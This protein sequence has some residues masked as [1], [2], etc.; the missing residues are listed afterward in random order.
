MANE[1]E[2]LEEIRNLLR[3]N[4]RSNSITPASTSSGSSGGDALNISGKLTGITTDVATALTRVWQGSTTA[5]DGLNLF[6]TSLSKNGGPIG[7]IL[8]DLGSTAIT[9]IND[10]NKA[11]VKAA[12]Y[13]AAQGNNLGEFDKAVKGA[14]MTHE[15]Y[16]DMLRDATREMEG[17]GSTAGRSQQNMLEIM[18]SVQESK[19]ANNLK[20]L[21]VSTEEINRIT[22]TSLAFRQGEDLHDKKAR[23]E[24]VESAIAMARAMDENTRISGLSRKAQE[25]DLKK[26]SEDAALQMSLAKLGPEARKQYEEA[27]TQ[28][29][30]MPKAVKDAFTEEFTGG[31]RTEG[32]AATIAALGDAGPELLKSAEAIRDANNPEAREQ[33]NDKLVGAITGVSKVQRTGSYLDLGIVGTGAAAD[34][35]REM[36]TEN[37]ELQKINA[38]IAEEKSK[39]STIDEATARKMIV[40]EVTNE[41]KKLDEKGEPLKGGELGQT[42]NKADSALKDMAA[43]ASVAFDKLV[44]S[45]NGV[46]SANQNYVDKVLKPR[47]QEEA[48]PAAIGKEIGD[49]IVKA[50]P[51]DAGKL[52]DAYSKRHQEYQDANKN[53]EEL[54]S[55]APKRSTGSPPFENFLSG[56]G[57]IKDMFESFDP[58]GELVELHG[59]ELVA[60]ESQMNRL[61]GQIS[62]EMQPTAISTASASDSAALNFEDVK[63]TVANQTNSANPQM[64]D[65]NKTFTAVNAEMKNVTTQLSTVADKLK[66]INFEPALKNLS[67]HT[68]KIMEA[69]AKPVVAPPVVTPPVVAKSAEPKKE[70]PKKEEVKKEEVKKEEVKPAETKPVEDKFAALSKT[71]ESVTTEIQSGGI[72][73]KEGAEKMASLGPAGADLEKAIKA[74]KDATTD[75]QKA[76]AINAENAAVAKIKDYQQSK[77]I[78]EQQQQQAIMSA[79]ASFKEID[80][81][82]STEELNKKLFGALKVDGIEKKEPPKDEKPK[83]PEKV[84]EKKEEKG[85]FDNVSDAFTKVGSSITD[86]FKDE[87][88]AF[89]KGNVK[90]E[91]IP[92]EEQDAAT[93]RAQEGIGK[94]DNSPEAM[95]AQKAELD[96]QKNSG[97]YKEAAPEKPKTDDLKKPA[98]S[99]EDA[100]VKEMYKTF[101]LETFKDYNTRLDAESKAAK[102]V[103]KD[104]SKKD[105]TTKVDINANKP[106][107]PNPEEIAK[108]VAAKTSLPDLTKPFANISEQ[109]SGAITNK[110]PMLNHEE[111]FTKAQ[112]MFKSP[113]MSNMLGSVGNTVSKM[114]EENNLFPE[115]KETK[116]ESKDETT[117]VTEKPKSIA[118]ILKNETDAIANAMNGIKAPESTESKDEKDEKGFFDTI[119]DTFNDVGSSISDMFKEDKSAETDNTKTQLAEKTPEEKAE[120]AK[121]QAALTNLDKGATTR[122]AIEADK[123]KLADKANIKETDKPVVPAAVVTPKSKED[124]NVDAM[125]KK[126]G[127]E[128][129]DD[130]NARKSAEVKSSHAQIKDISTD[131][132]KISAQ[133][134]TPPKPIEQPKP[135]EQVKPAEQLV[136]AAPVN[137]EVTLKDLHDALLQLNKTMGQMAQHTDAISS[138]SRKQVQATQ[139]AS[140]NRYA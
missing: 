105:D 53:R 2:L 63:N 57:G 56:S 44:Q 46:I 71:I 39:G 75:Q 122:A 47:K 26:R 137:K 22:E 79:N 135:A 86:L 118:E 36:Y 81:I 48:T 115:I 100:H 107:L 25:D 96:R 119:S 138:N 111:L 92:Q 23:A 109:L 61:F 90:Y 50:L 84:E 117:A 72:R 28:M 99:K 91:T 95:A 116:E 31:I 6:A 106:S 5:A 62:K 125:Y 110:S 98:E 126:F 68:A 85:F 60:N 58:N 16:S 130:Y 3:A 73:T 17:I 34:K 87:K 43:G 77:A 88:P 64:T 97:R 13:G 45:T 41:R 101:G 134:V 102:P 108:Q 74:H 114:F 27:M 136:V 82:K 76:D 29:A 59:K 4:N 66:N 129:F 127:L 15:Q 67:E 12:E 9:A 21:G 69:V 131:R 24:A 33:A 1:R 20:E 139:A 123:A 128:R 8:G 10:V 42:I 38:K 132:S 133:D 35:S 120:D 7:K 51:F 37:L 30:N 40:A 112:E 70:E 121:V 83:T 89:A 80:P 55:E 124:Q 140:G 113:D 49:A 18:K 14:R 19:L 11:N 93:K 52:V 78:I 32:G 103:V 94:V 54:P 104:E 65:I